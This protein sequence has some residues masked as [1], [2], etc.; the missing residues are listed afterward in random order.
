MGTLKK[1]TVQFGLSGLL[2]YLKIKTGATNR[3]RLRGL[4]HSIRLRPGTSDVTTFKHIFAHGDYDFQFTPAP[5]VIVD[6]GANVGLAAVY[7]ANRYPDAQIIAIELSPDNFHLLQENTRHYPHISIIHAGLWPRHETLKF[8]Q[9]GVS[10]WGYKVNN[11]LTDNSISVKSVTIPDILT[12]YQIA[13]IDLLKIDIEG[14]EVELFSSSCEAWLPKV[15]HII[16]EFHDRW[17]PDSS[18]VV[19]DQ[20]ARFQFKESGTVG[21]NVVFV[22]TRF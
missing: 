9:E 10:P 4:P 17:R 7:F 2:A 15:R 13:T 3:I 22:N 6:A 11:S 16:I 12:K 19:R 8:Q 1:L 14:A 20:L 21:E 5:R 18:R